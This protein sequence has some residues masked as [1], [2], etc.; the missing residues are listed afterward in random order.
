MKLIK[1]IILITLGF[2]LSVPADAHR[3]GCHRWHS[4]PS[5]S[6][7]YVCGDLGYCSQCPDN[8]YCKDGLPRGSAPQEQGSSES[9]TRLSVPASSSIL[10]GTVMRVKDG[11]TVVIRPSEGG[12]FYTCRLYGIDAPEKDQRYGDEATK[13]LKSLILGKGVMISTTG[14]RTYG[15]EVCIIELGGVDINREMVRMGYAWAYRKYLDSPYASEYI[16]AENRA[17]AKGLG[18]WRDNNPMP[19][20]EFRRL[21][22]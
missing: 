15:R 12:Q 17:R 1:L 4:C 16:E 8:Q 10:W 19:P 7:S 20:W 2:L 14:D 5:D 3:S 9:D 6:G 13:A 22:Q 21:K 18:L 11:D